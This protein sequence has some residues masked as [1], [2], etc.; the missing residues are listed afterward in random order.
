MQPSN[1][2]YELQE[3][4]R[5]RRQIEHYDVNVPGLLRLLQRY[6]ELYDAIDRFALDGRNLPF[7]DRASRDRHGVYVRIL[8][9]SLRAVEGELQLLRME[10]A[11]E[12]RAAMNRRR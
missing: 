9:H 3:V 8:T 11:D 2:D 6:E 10:L 5:L 1:H 4:K 12:F 7:W